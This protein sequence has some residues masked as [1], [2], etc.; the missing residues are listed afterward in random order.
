M[1]EYVSYHGTNE[2][3]KKAYDFIGPG[4]P[5]YNMLKHRGLTMKYRKQHNN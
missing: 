5:K 2:L 4:F 3:L 1:Y